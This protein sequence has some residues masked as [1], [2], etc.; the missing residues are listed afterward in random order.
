VVRGAVRPLGENRTPVPSGMICLWCEERIGA[1]DSGVW[2]A[3][4]ATS[5]RPQHAECFWRSIVGSRRHQLRKCSCYGNGG[6]EDDEGLTTRE[7]AKAAWEA[8]RELRE[9]LPPM[10]PPR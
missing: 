10:W 2:Q 6:A 8:F 4:G 7:A 9:E 1:E 5:A 3:Y